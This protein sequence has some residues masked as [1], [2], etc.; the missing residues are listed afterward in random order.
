M[1]YYTYDSL[2]DMLQVQV[3]NLPTYQGALGLNNQFVLD[4]TN[5]LADLEYLKDYSE[6]I[7][8]DKKAV[9]QIKAAVYNGDSNVPASPFPVF[10]VAAPPQS[11]PQT[12]ILERTQQRNRQIK[13]APGYTEEIGVALGIAGGGITAQSPSS[14]TPTIEV[15]AGAS[16][17]MFSCV[18]G[19]RV[20]SDSWIVQILRTGGSSWQNTGTFTGKSADV[21]ISLTNPGQPE[22]IQVRIQL[23]KSNADYGNV[24]A[25][26]TV[27]VNP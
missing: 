8:Q 15:F 25:A 3:A 7:D 14:V 19:N 17:A 6:I 4:V 16:G 18:V 13:A 5:D 24:S 20:D 1:A 9:F 10:P 11:P 22:Q 27:T 2:I 21:N 12:G 26:L 23:R